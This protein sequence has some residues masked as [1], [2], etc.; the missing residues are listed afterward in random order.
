VAFPILL[1]TGLSHGEASQTHVALITLPGFHPYNVAEHFGKFSVSNRTETF[2]LYLNALD[3]FS[4]LPVDNFPAQPDD[5]K[6][7]D[8]S[9]YIKTIYPSIQRD[10]E[11]VADVDTLVGV[12]RRTQKHIEPLPRV[13]QHRDANPSNWR[14]VQVN[15]EKYINLIDLETVGLA[16]RGWDEGRLYSL[17]SLD[18]QKQ[19]EFKD[20]VYK[21]PSFET[22]ESQMYF[23]R[24]VLF[25][26]MRE[27]K[28]INSGKYNTPITLYNQQNSTNIEDSIKSGIVKTVRQTM[29]ELERII[30]TNE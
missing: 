5:E 4:N 21:H 26:S 17:M 9:D 18:P 20:I 23:W 1:K 15:E 22:K 2:S 25:R 16:R 24:V 13:I 11:T 7:E 6:F 27:L 3:A 29:N 30:P 28:L 8:V 10:I 12:F 14:V 19:Q